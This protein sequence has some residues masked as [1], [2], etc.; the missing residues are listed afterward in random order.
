MSRILD[1]N[2]DF[3]DLVEYTAG[4]WTTPPH[5]HRWAAT[6][7]IAACLEDRVYS[8]VMGKEEPLYP[9]LW[10]FLIGPQGTGKDHAIGNVMRLLQPED[11]LWILNGRTTIPGLYDYLFEQQ[12]ATQR[13]SAPAFLV[14]SDVAVQLPRG[15]EAM[16]FS[17]RIVDMYGG[18]TQSIT[19]R[20]RTGG[21]KVIHRPVI[22][23]YAGTTPDWFPEAIDPITFKSGFAGRGIFVFGEPRLEFLK[24]MRVIHHHD[25]DE[26]LVHLRKRV[27]MFQTIEGEV[28]WDD[29]ARLM[30]QYFLED[31]ARDAQ[32]GTAKP[33]EIEVATRI[34]MNVQKLAIVYAVSEWLGGK[35]RITD[36]AVARAIAARAEIV[37]GLEK[38][39][40]FAFLTPE[41]KPMHAVLNQIK[42]S[43]AGRIA[44]ARLLK[45]GL[46]HGVKDRDHFKRII[47]SLIETGYIERDPQRG[48]P[49]HPVMYYRM[50]RK[51]ALLTSTTPAVD[52]AKKVFQFREGVEATATET[53]EETDGATAVQNEDEDGGNSTAG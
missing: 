35:L 12:K 10:I 7:L 27:E 31:M 8:I 46:H 50:K 40:R 53:E 17:S 41:T 5:F 42:L 44:H 36:T 33:E 1:T 49:G 20:T 24:L 29:K 11:A 19:D 37:L 22:N 9:N 16:D 28:E 47:D 25:R 45:F 26:V 21:V 43:P 23:W 14:T 39:H 2:R 34:R 52:E 13:P 48:K 6:S 15:A 4:E 18:R 3:I 38:I 51:L 30:F 32:M